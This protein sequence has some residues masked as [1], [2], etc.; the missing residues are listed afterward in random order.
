MHQWKGQFFT[1]YCLKTRKSIVKVPPLSDIWIW[2]TIVS[3]P[4]GVGTIGTPSAWA[5]LSECC[6]SRSRVRALWEFALLCT[7]GKLDFPSICLK[8]HYQKWLWNSAFLCGLISMQIFG[9]TS[10]LS[11]M[12]GANKVQTW[13]FSSS[14]PFFLPPF[15]FLIFWVYY[16]LMLFL[17]KIFYIISETLWVCTCLWGMI[18]NINSISSLALGL[19]KFSIFKFLI[20]LIGI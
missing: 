20:I 18:S 14:L 12:K 1:N 10:E 9:N 15:F 5:I 13:F 6:S 17:L 8:K 2:C 4:E 11:K 7:A 19:F 3:F 16:K